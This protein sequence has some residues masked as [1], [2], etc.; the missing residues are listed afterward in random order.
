MPFISFYNGRLRTGVNHFTIHDLVRWIIRNKDISF[1]AYSEAV[2]LFPF[3]SR[4][5]KGPKMSET[6][7]QFFLESPNK[8]MMLG[9]VLNILKESFFVEVTQ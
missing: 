3:D 4:I 2:L 5:Y 7:R 9:V 8:G 1:G 6:E